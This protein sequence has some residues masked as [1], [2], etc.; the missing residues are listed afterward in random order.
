MAA[1]PPTN[2]AS[3]RLGTG[4]LVLGAANSYTGGTTVDAG[5][6]QLG[7]GGSLAST[8]ALTVNAGTFDLNGHTQTV[9]DVLGPRRHGS[10][11]GNGGRID[12]HRGHEPPPMPASSPAAAA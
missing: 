11:L 10:N 12:G 3:A 4:T 5:I 8:G 1:A 2:G 6:L 7:A 9:G